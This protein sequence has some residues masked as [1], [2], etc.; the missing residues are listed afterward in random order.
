M[1]DREREST[2]QLMAAREAEAQY[3]ASRLPTA[4]PPAPASS[5][6]IIEREQKPEQHLVASG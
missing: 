1:T 5:L 6:A 4:D 2:M 3:G